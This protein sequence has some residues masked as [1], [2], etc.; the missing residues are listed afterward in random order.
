MNDL[1]DAI[2]KNLGYHHLYRVDPNTQDMPVKEKI[3]GTPAVAQAAIPAVLCGILIRLKSTGAAAM[4]LESES[5]D[6]LGTIFGD[7]KDV[8]IEKISGYACVSPLTAKQESE[9][10]AHEAVR[11][12]RQNLADKKQDSI[13]SLITN[14]MKDILLYLPASLQVGTLLDNNNLDDQTNKME[15]PISSFMRQLEKQ[16]DSNK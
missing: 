3:F 6:W 1:I 2:Q 13:S 12:I 15:G 8:V 14:N 5:P 7:K 11:V 16:F 4:I 10:I 9:H